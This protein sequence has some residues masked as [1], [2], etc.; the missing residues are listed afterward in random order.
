MGPGYFPSVLGALLGVI[1]LISIVRS[2]F[3][4]GDPMER[5]AFK[6]V[7]LI[8]FSVFLFGA[9]VR[10]A[11]LIVSIFVIVMLGGLASMKFRWKASLLL[12]IGSAIF[13]VAIFVKGLGL[14]MPIIG[15][16][17]GY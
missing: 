16:W 10:G 7:F 5:L 4:S 2:F 13:C 6:Q 11:G 12:A 17:F 8:L 1:G 15:S 3:S 14:P 9:L